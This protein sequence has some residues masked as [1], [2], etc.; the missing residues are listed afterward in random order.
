MPETIDPAQVRT[1][2]EI[3]AQGSKWA[4]RKLPG[5]SFAGGTLD[6]ICAVFIGICI[7]GRYGS[8]ESFLLLRA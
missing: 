6:E 7:E 1:T 3:L 8:Y 2:S 4:P 5:S